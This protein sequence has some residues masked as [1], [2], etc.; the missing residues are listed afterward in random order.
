VRRARLLDGVDVVDVSTAFAGPYA[1]KLLADLGA[2]VIHVE[3]GD[4]LDIMRGYPPFGAPEGPDRSGSFASIN[5]NKLGITLNLKT[6]GGRDVMARLVCRADVLLENYTPRVLPSLGFPWEHLARL[7]P[8]LVYCTMPGFGS[9]GPHRDYRSYGPTLEGQSGLA[10]MTGYEGEPP[11]RMGCSY[12][13]M[14]GGVTAAFAIVA[15]LRRR[16]RT[17]R[18]ALIEVPQQQA[19]AALTGIAVVQWTLTGRESGRAGNAH[20]WFVPHGVYRCAGDDHWVAVVVRDDAAW[21]RLAPL[22]GLGPMTHAARC[23]RRDEID[24]AL[25]RFAAAEDRDALAR[26]LQALGIEAYPVRTALELARDAHL[27]ARRFIEPIDHPT[28]GPRAYAGPPWRLAGIDTAP[29][30]PAPRL[31]EHTEGVLAALG[32]TPAEI[33][34]LRTEG[35]LR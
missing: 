25:G 2:R 16:A 20:P 18:G 19:A 4:R 32:Y 33:A 13:D 6:A 30:T 7:N 5:R 9:S 14:V 34:Q 35:A 12:P 27:A 28:L 3:T 1:G 11:L 17:G 8:R 23:A 15:A 31:G 10:F 29:H 22:L 26:R 21:T 24:A